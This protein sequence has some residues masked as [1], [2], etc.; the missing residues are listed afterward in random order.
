MSISEQQVQSALEEITDLSTGKNYVVSNEAR[1]IKIDGD[2]VSLDIVLGYPAKS[3]IEGI[4]KQVVDRLK[5]IPG[6]GDVNVNITS[7]IVSHSVQRGVKLIPGV[8][9]II[10]V[11][12]GKGGV[13]KS[14]TAVN[15]ALALAAEGA[16]RRHTGCR[17]LWSLTAPDAGNYWPPRIA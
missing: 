12:S 17:H 1:N 5:S 13:G 10:A 8:K 7:K 15:L 2:H 14:A 3:V 16:V 4:R 11:A 9:N 6:I